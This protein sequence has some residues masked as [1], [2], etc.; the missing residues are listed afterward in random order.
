M[1]TSPLRVN[2]FSSSLGYSLDVP[3][4]QCLECRSAVQDAWL[5][6]I[7]LE[8]QDTKTRGGD[9]VFLTFTYRPSCLPRTN[10]G[11]ADSDSVVCFNKL[12]VLRFLNNL[13][14][15]AYNLFGPSSYKYFICSEYGS[16][17]H[18]P[19][20]HG[21]FFLREGVDYTQ[22]T[23]LCRKLWKLGFMFPRNL[24]GHYVDN[25]L[26]PSTPLVNNMQGC[27][28]YCA[29]YVTKDLDFYGDALVKQYISIR[30]NLSV[31]S[32]R[33]FNSYLPKHFQSKGLGARTYSPAQLD[34]YLK[35]G[36]VNPATRRVV[37][38]PRYYIERS[39]FTH[40][41]KFVD[42]KPFV[43][44]I[45]KADYH[46]VIRTLHR[47]SIEQK[48]K[49]LCDFSLSLSPYDYKRAGYSISDYSH[50]R[51]LNSNV[52]ILSSNYVKYLFYSLPNISRSLYLMLNH[53]ISVDSWLDYRML[54]YNPYVDIDIPCVPDL[55]DFESDLVDTF[56][57][58]FKVMAYARNDTNVRRYHD[59]EQIR[60]LKLHNKGLI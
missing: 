23:E 9:V 39:A 21:M 47:Q 14:V 34:L 1:C 37:S 29:K 25:Q 45:L 5:F 32:Q 30:K 57:I 7:G 8:Y 36:V 11:F 59:F 13:K 60:K 55:S 41:V 20:Y 28:Q 17:T 18:R 58:Y 2:P 35:N 24:H 51:S 6:R 54:M 22:F 3:C 15:H 16:T 33:H 49:Q 38:L 43:E 53:S 42:G 52:N 10:F 12:D 50:F 26:L 31:A 56:L 40:S 48:I 27:V 44:R 46:D 4:N 19:H